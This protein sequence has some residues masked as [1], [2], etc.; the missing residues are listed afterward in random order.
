M[1]NVAKLID[2]DG[3]ARSTVMPNSQ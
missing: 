1:D 2:L 3:Q